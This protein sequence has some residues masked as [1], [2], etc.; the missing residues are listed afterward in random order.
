MLLLHR[1]AYIY[2]TIL[3]FG[4]ADTL[5]W[6][7]PLVSGLIA[8]TFF[9]VDALAEELE[10]PFRDRPNALPLSHYAQVVE[11]TM[12]RALGEEDLPELA[13]PVDYVLH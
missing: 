3:P 8:Y 13:G 4:F 1:T 5:G 11:I 7:A 10:E 12:R 2:C 6:A 9:G